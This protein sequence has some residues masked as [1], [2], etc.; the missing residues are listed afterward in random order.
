MTADDPR[1]STDEGILP[2]ITPVVDMATH[3]GP[4]REWLTQFGYR[5]PDDHGMTYGLR[6]ADHHDANSAAAVACSQR[7]TPTRGF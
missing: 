7:T 4:W 6:V 2:G 3:C 1:L 5:L